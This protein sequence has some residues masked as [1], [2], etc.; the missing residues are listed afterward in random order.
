MSE[1]KL[2][3]IRTFS[4]PAARLNAEMAKGL[5]EQEGIDCLLPGEFS[6]DLM[7]G[8]DVVQLLVRKEDASAAAQ[9]LST[10]FDSPA[11]PPSE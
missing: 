10:Y 11:S 2:V 4:G 3:R 7:P 6:A 9:L 5:L 1:A 8:L